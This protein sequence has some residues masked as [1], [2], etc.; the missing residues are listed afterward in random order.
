MKILF[1]GVLDV[2][3]S[4]NRPMKRVLE[5]LG[6]IVVDFN[7]RTIAQ[8]HNQKKRLSNNLLDGWID[9]SA[10]FLRSSKTP[11]KIDW[12]YKRNGRKEMNDLLLE[13][14]K[15]DQFDLVL[16]CKTD[17]VNYRLLPEINR[18]SPTWY[19]FMDPMDQARRI[20]AVAYAKRATWASATFSDVTEYFKNAGARA[21]WITQ[22]VDTNVFMH[23]ETSKSYDVVFVGTKTTKRFRYVEALRKAGIIIVCF[24]EGWEN[25]PVYRAELVDIYCKSRVVLNFCRPGSGFSIRI[26]QVMGAGA[27]LLSEYCS[28]M[29]DIFERG[30]HLDWFKDTQ[31]LVEK[32]CY[33]LNDNQSLKTISSAGHDFVRKNYSW[34]NIINDICEIV[35]TQHE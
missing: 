10:S 32:A 7:Y 3:W 5:G 30:V 11:I 26:F 18:Y 28:D 20:N 17:S 22:G 33:Y 8:Q 4:T 34:E 25:G 27:F 14:V 23:N 21:Y 31:E 35:E 2:D 1:V 16:F 19:F 24:G 6:H 12:Y 15:K 9:R 13:T 29:E